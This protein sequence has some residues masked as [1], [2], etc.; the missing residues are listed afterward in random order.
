MNS[1]SWEGLGRLLLESGSLDQ[2][3]QA[4]NQALKINPKSASAWQALGLILYKEHKPDGAI[5]DFEKALSIQPDFPDAS[6]NMANALLARGK[7]ATAVVTLKTLLAKHADSALGWATLGVAYASLGR[8]DDAIA[9]QQNSIRLAPKE[10]GF[11][12]NLAHTYEL[13]HRKE[14]QQK[15]LAIANQLQTKAQGGSKKK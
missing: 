13:L 7:Y 8:F 10:P 2:A 3:A 11:H 12:G 15:E 1:Q 4:Y 9:A 5:Q 6:I 14:E